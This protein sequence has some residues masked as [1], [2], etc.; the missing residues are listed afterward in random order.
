[1]IFQAPWN[2]SDVRFPQSDH[3]IEEGHPLHEI[4]GIKIH[5]PFDLAHLNDDQDMI[6]TIAARLIAEVQIGCGKIETD[7]PIVAARSHRTNG[8]LACQ[9]LRT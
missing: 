8:I 4:V 3:C 5:K 2:P 1:M 9:Q 7:V 6:Q